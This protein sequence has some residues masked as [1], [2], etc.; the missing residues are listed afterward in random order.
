MII[1][2]GLKLRK[3]LP[4]GPLE[5]ASNL[6]ARGISYTGG[7]DIRGEFVIHEPADPDKMIWCAEITSAGRGKRRKLV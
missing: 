6:L 2:V 3:M 1:V 5:E 4:V 7:S